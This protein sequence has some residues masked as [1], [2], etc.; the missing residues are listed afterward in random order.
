[1]GRP[2]LMPQRAGKVHSEE[3]DQA[4]YGKSLRKVI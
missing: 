1:M 4:T 2:L 3:E